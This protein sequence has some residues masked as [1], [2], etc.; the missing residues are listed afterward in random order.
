[1]LISTETDFDLSK[2]PPRDGFLHLRH[3]ESFRACLVQVSTVKIMYPRCFLF[4]RLMRIPLIV[5]SPHPTRSLP[6]RD[7][8]V[9]QNGLLIQ[10]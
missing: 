3:P 7:S 5:R 2:K 10:C 1:M 6:Y 4:P 9:S 8:L